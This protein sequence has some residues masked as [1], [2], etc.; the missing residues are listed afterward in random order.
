[1]FY[2]LFS[3]LSGMLAIYLFRLFV[4]F[5]AIASSLTIDKLLLLLLSCG[6]VYLCHKRAGLL[7]AKNCASLCSHEAVY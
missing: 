7:F 5:Y 3:P 6:R 1:M 4:Y 2:G